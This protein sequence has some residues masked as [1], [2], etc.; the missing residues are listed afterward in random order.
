[1]Y[2]SSEGTGSHGDISS[3]QPEAGQAHG[4]VAE[5]GPPVAAQPVE[6]EPHHGE[7]EQG[8]D[9]EGSHPP[10]GAPYG[11]EQHHFTLSDRQAEQVALEVDLGQ[12]FTGSVQ[13]PGP[14]PTMS[15]SR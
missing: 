4:V 3:D 14:W 1:M 9:A 11:F 15:L 6:G 13:K 8:Q 7:G 5:E 12:G 10:P 2:A